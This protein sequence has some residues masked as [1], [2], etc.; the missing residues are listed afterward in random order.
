MIPAIMI[1]WHASLAQ[2]REYSIS[3]YRVCT[4]N[5]G[6]YVSTCKF[7][8]H[9]ISGSIWKFCVQECWREDLN[10]REEYHT[11]KWLMQVTWQSAT[12]SQNIP[13]VI[14]PTQDLSYLIPRQLI[15]E[16]HQNYVNYYWDSCRVCKM[17][18]ITTPVIGLQ[19]DYLALSWNIAQVAGEIWG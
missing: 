12:L 10:S 15:Y 7:N 11:T 17:R 9:A 1:Y 14:W 18:L 19:I 5:W 16:M 4:Y 6:A 2:S 13:K 8:S 3:L